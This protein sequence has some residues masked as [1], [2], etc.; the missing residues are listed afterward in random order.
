MGLS[1][2]KHFSAHY[3]FTREDCDGNPTNSCIIRGKKTKAHQREF[4]E[5]ILATVTLDELTAF[6]PKLSMACKCNIDQL[7][8]IFI[9]HV[10]NTIVPTYGDLGALA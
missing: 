9:D 7:S 4:D 2:G 10:L 6:I 1:L 5:M 3:S 8:E